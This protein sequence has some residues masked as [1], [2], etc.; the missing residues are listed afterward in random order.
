MTG[1]AAPRIAVIGPGAIG[2]VIAALLHDAGRPV[3][4]AGRSPRRDLRLDTAHG[5]IVVPGPV[6]TDPAHSPGAMDLVFLAV[7]ATQTDAAAAWLA[8]LC[9]PS[10]IVCV[11]QNGIEQVE[12]VGPLVPESTVLPAI[13]WSPAER[14]PDGSVR[15]RGEPRFTVP[16]SDGAERVGDALD[17][18]A[19]EFAVSDDFT[20]LAWR[21][22]LQ[23]A[24]AG[25]MALTGRRAGMFR[26]QDVGDLALAYLQEGL[27]VARACGAALPD[28]EPDRML[29][30]F[31]AFPDDMGTSI[32]ADREAG[33][34]LE[35]DARNAVIRRRGR[36]HGIPTPV[37]DVIVPLLAAASDGPG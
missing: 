35:W 29:E 25:L 34:P 2:T 6:L 16:Q 17:A 32:L 14:R 8:A 21:K 12:R 30:R 11:L 9:G 1:S 19:C 28:D 33:R 26:R 5:S 27:A 31:R 18:T 23:N 20:T 13:V 10:T 15:S 7:K 37:T 3:L 24:V 4:V 22:L 36:E